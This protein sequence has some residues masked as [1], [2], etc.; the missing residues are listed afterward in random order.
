MACGGVFIVTCIILTLSLLIC[1][2]RR[3]HKHA[4][5]ATQEDTEAA[6]YE[7]VK[8]VVDNKEFKIELNASYAVTRKQENEPVYAEI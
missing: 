7:E 4:G 6:T 5:G 2:T 1:G 3:A 8:D